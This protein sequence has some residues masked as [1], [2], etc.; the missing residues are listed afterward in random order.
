MMGGYNYGYGNQSYGNPGPQPQAQPNP[1]EEAT[2]EEKAKAVIERYKADFYNWIWYADPIIFLNALMLFNYELKAVE[3]KE[4]EDALRNV[5]C[6]SLWR[7]HDNTLYMFYNVISSLYSNEYQKRFNQGNKQNQNQQFNM[8]YQQPGP[9]MMGGPQM[10]GMGN[11]NYQMGMGGMGPQ[12]GMPMGGG[13]GMQMPYQQQPMMGGMGPQMN[14]NGMMPPMN[15]MGMPMGGMNQY[16][17]MG[18]MNPQMGMS[19]GGGMGYGMPYQQ[20]MAGG[21]GAPQQNRSSP[22][23]TPIWGDTGS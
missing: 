20:P 10:M 19:M 18:G 21:F 14:M 1:K 11:Y 9:G 23:G 16:G 13:M 3:N 6:S 15:G 7:I 17:M 12:M 22:I 8:G 2:E 4:L 5:I